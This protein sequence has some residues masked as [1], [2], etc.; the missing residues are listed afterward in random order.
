MSPSPIEF[1]LEKALWSAVDSVRGFGAPTVRR[2]CIHIVHPLAYLSM[3]L[4]QGFLMV[5]RQSIACIGDL[6]M[7]AIFRH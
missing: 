1:A 4:L 7:M 2:Q 6:F 5:L 3:Q